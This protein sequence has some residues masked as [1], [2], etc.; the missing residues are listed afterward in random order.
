MPA[1]DH[2]AAAARFPDVPA[3]AGHYESFYLKACAPGGGRAV[4][5]RYTVH[6]R[7]GAPPTGALWFTLFD[8]AAGISAAKASVD[9]PRAGAGRYLELG[10]ARIEPG[11][12]RGAALQ[13]SWDVSWSAV[14]EPLWHLPAGWM[15]SGSFPRT[16]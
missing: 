8:A 11:R 15:Y 16:K 4:W 10:E 13:A 12:A 7:A 3:A 2:T 9:D 5:I 1:A 6:K 14:E